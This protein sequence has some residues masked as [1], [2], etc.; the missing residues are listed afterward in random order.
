MEG[1]DLSPYIAFVGDIAD[2]VGTAIPTVLT[3][4]AVIGGGLLLVTV[5]WKLVRRFAK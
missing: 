4:V 2:A 5:A 1:I 3:A